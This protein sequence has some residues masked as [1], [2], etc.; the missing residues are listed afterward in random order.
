MKWLQFAKDYVQWKKRW[1]K[2]N[3]SDVKK[4]NLD[5]RD[6]FNYYFN[7]LRKY[8]FIMSRRQAGGHSIMNE[9]QSV[10]YTQLQWILTSVLE[11]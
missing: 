5:G 6:D 3:F 8:N 2:V 11:K 4:F 9:H 10:L 1:S 7:D